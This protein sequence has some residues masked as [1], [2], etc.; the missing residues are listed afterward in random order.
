MS[1]TKIKLDSYQELNSDE[2][3]EIVQDLVNKVINDKTLSLAEENF[4]CGIMSIMRCVNNEPIDIKTYTNCN[5]YYFRSKYLIYHNDLNGHKKIVDYNGEINFIT[6]Q[7]D[8]NYLNQTFRNWLTFMDENKDIDNFMKY[9]YDENCFHLK[10]LKKYCFKNN[11]GAN[12]RIYLEKSITLHS[13][14]IYLLVKEF[15]QELGNDEIII[16]INNYN[17]LINP[18]SYIHIMFRHFSGHIK[19]YQNK[20]YH[21]DEYIGFKNIPTILLEILNLYKSN[22]I[23]TNFNGVSLYLRINTKPYSIYFRKIF[24]SNLNEN[25][26]RLQTFFPIG[27]IKELEKLSNLQIVRISESIEIYV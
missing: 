6:K 8:V 16:N 21:F 19:E 5:N 7:E 18:F 26:Y 11:Y 23:N 2:L 24:N 10:A 15:F 9:I 12:Y 14:Y 27:E 1:Y 4:I 20:T 17:I 25:V 13:K 22:T 3:K